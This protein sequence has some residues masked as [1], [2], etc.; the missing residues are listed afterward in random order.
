MTPSTDQKIAQRYS[1]TTLEKKNKNKTSL[2]QE[3]GWA[4]ETKRPVLCLPA[5]MS[6]SLGGKLL[7]QVLPGL[8]SLDVELLILGKGS[9]HYGELFT[10]LAKE[11]G[12]R[13]AIVPNEEVAIRKM[14][15]AAD[16]ALFLA[17]TSGTE[18]VKQALSYGVVP[19][20]PNSKGLT[21]Y[22]PVQESGNAF[23]YKGD[24]VWDCFGAIVRAVET[25]RFPYDWRTIQKQCME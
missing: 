19:I 17:D 2:Q 24:T 3:L 4:A 25:F 18:E 5:G 23:L 11:H 10:T 14:Y 16:M 7:E 1:A 22:N 6:E 20:A 15:A 9:S 12:H 13:I 21:E 8:L